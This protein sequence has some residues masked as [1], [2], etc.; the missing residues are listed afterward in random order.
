M[1]GYR[2]CL[3]MLAVWP[4]ETLGPGEVPG[5]PT[6]KWKLLVSWKVELVCHAS[7]DVVSVGE[8]LSYVLLQAAQGEL[9]GSFWKIL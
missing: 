1:D 4:Q 3:R 8:E 9:S 5:P 2:N 7:G 6:R